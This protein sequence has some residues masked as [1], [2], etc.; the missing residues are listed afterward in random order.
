LAIVSAPG[1]GELGHLV[2]SVR[3]SNACLSTVP[4][5]RCSERDCR[6]GCH[7]CRCT[8]PTVG[9]RR[10]AASPFLDSATAVAADSQAPAQP[11]RSQW[12]GRRRARCRRRGG[13]PC[14]AF[15]KRQYGCVTGVSRPRIAERRCHE[16]PRLSRDELTSTGGLDPTGCAEGSRLE[17]AY[18]ADDVSLSGRSPCAPRDGRR[19]ATAARLVQVSGGRAPAHPGAAGLR[20]VEATARDEPTGSARHG[21]ATRD[22]TVAASETAAS[23]RRLA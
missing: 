2:K 7:A 21:T 23:W 20:A 14:T 3:R 19:R 6:A 12:Y 5:R 17:R 15:R 9:R 16:P 10:I 11:A 18:Q 8:S 13:P 4:S 1:L 22:A